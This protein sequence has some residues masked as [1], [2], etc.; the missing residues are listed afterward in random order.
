MTD[1]SLLI[2]KQPLRSS[3]EFN[4]QCTTIKGKL[5]KLQIYFGKI[6]LQQH[7]FLVVSVLSKSTLLL[8]NLKKCPK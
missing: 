5:G 3:I 7:T 2:V 8:R 6:L 4:M 1:Q